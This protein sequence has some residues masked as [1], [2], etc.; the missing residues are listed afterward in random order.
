MH[1]LNILRLIILD[2]PLATDMR[3]FIGDAI[4]SAL[5]GYK[6]TSWAVRNSATMTFAAAMLRVI[7]ADKNAEN[8][9]KPTMNVSATYWVNINI[10]FDA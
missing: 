1:A 3:P 4:I 9:D 10:S 2:S 8:I 7:D 5:I 6:D